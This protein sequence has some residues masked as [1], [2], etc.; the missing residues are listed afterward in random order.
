[1]LLDLL[2]NLGM[3][4][5]PEVEAEVVL[6]A[7]LLVRAK[8]MVDF[9]IPGSDFLRRIE[10]YRSANDTAQKK[11]SDRELKE[12]TQMYAAARMARRRSA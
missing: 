2:I 8:P 6:T 10:V 3:F 9:V 11:N 5:E 12:M 4:G 7:P 1:M